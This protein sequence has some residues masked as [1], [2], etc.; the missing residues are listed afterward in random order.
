MRVYFVPAIV[1]PAI[2]PDWPKIIAS[3]GC[4]EVM[5]SVPIDNPPAGLAY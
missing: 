4:C 3:T 2:S 1:A 5:V